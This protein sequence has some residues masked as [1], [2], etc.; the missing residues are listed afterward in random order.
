MI[1]TLMALMLSLMSTAPNRHLY[2]S[3]EIRREYAEYF[4]SAGRMSGVHPILLVIWGY[5][6]SSLRTSAVGKLGE[7]GIFQTHGRAKKI[8]EKHYDLKTAKGQIFCG[9]SIIALY[10]KHCKTLKRGLY[11]YSSARGGCN[12]TPRGRRI[13]ERRLRR[14][15]KILFR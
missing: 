11:A 12:G 4:V 5:G 6:E 14:W 10:T 3:E 7:Q 9:A 8:C 1:E 13:T 15:R 2:K